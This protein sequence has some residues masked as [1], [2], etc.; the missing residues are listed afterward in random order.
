MII[1]IGA[2]LSGLTLARYLQ[3]RDVPFRIFDQSDAQRPQ[4]YGLTMR[5]RAIEGLLPILGICEESFRTAVAVDRKDGAIDSQIIDMVTGEMANVSPYS[6]EAIKDF[7]CNRK[8]LRLMI[9][10][11]LKIEFNHKLTSIRED[12]DAV[13]ASFA[14]GAEVSGDLLVAADGLHSFGKLLHNRHCSISYLY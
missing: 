3:S 9:Q 5:K 11:S 1:I 12:N 8:R 4:G 2:G 13:V 14:N 10:G 6:S 7:R